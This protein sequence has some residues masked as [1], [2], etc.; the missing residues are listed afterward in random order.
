MPIRIKGVT[1]SRVG[2]I[3]STLGALVA[4]MRGTHVAP[5]NRSGR[6]VV[7]LGAVAASLRGQSSV[8]ANRNGRIATNLGTL[9]A[10]F[11]GTAT[12]PGTRNG[13]IIS[14]LGGLTSSL[15]GTSA[16]PA[17]PQTGLDFPGNLAAVN[18]SASIRFRWTGSAL[19]PIF[20][21]GGAGVTYIWKYRPL[22]HTG[23]YSTFFWGNDDGAGA[24]STFLWQS[25]AANSYYG[26]HPYPQGGA[27]GTVHNWEVSVEQNDF[28]GALVTKGVWHSQATRVR[29]AVNA[30]KEH[31]FYWNLPNLDAANRVFRTSPT[32]W[33]NVNPP[34]P[35]LTWAD[36]PWQPS[37]ERGAGVHRGIQ[38]YNAYLTTSQIVQLAALESDAAVLSMA[39]SLGLSSA[40]WY[41][42]MNPTPSDISDKSGAGHTPLWVNANRPALYSTDQPPVW[43]GLPSTITFTQGVAATYDVSQHVTDPDTPAAN[44][45][46]TKNATAL[47]IGVTFDAPQKR[48]VYDPTTPGSIVAGTNGHI[49]TA[50]D[51]TGAAGVDVTMFTLTSNTTATLP[52][53]IG[54]AF[55]Q[56]DIPSGQFIVSD[57]STF[58]GSIRNRWPDGSVKYAVLSGRKLLTNGTPSTVIVRRQTADPGGVNI[59]EST[60]IGLNPTVSMTLSSF[61]TVTLSAL[62]GS[63]VRSFLGTQMSEFHYRSAVGS[64]AHLAVWFYVRVY[65]GNAIEIE[66]CVENGYMKVASP[67]NKAYTAT[68]T[69]NGTTRY[70][71]ALT[72]WPRTRWFTVNW[73]DGSSG[74]TDFARVIPAHNAS[75]LRSTKLV[76]NYATTAA[77]TTAYLNGLP[78]NITPLGNGSMPAG[79]LSAGGSAPH[80]GILPQWAAS[81]CVNGDARAYRGTL[82]N[83]YCSNSWPV[84]YRDE[85][86]QR[87]LALTTRPNLDAAGWGID[88]V[89]AGTGSNGNSFGSGTQAHMP[90]AGY[91]AYLLTGR[92]TYLETAAF[93]A[94]RSHMEN[95]PTSRGLT[96]G[97]G[98]SATIMTAEDRGKSWHL[99]T[100]MQVVSIYP[101]SGLPA[102]D[103]LVR[104]DWLAALG[105]TWTWY[106]TNALACPLGYMSQHFNPGSYHPDQVTLPNLGVPSFMGYFHAQCVGYTWDLDVLSGTAKTSHTTCR[107]HFYKFP[108]GMC[109]DSSGWCFRAAAQFV[110]AIGTYNGSTITWDAT[111]AAAYARSDTSGPADI[112]P[113]ASKPCTAGG[114]IATGHWPDSTS[115]G[116]NLHPAIAYAV[117]HGATGAAAAYAR[118]QAAS[119][120]AAFVADQV[121][122]TQ[123]AIVPRT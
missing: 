55:K 100:S 63:P 123:W 71:A 34:A 61:G 8:P 32:T 49:L 50:D 60:L 76:P 28:I 22:Q 9:A 48:Y 84:C 72:H 119:N 38:I 108:V 1:D 26:M 95:N 43:T 115:Y 13:R 89:V 44:I 67:V 74:L 73:Y 113:D 7:G 86:T 46:I 114:S 94:A 36:A 109:G 62:F 87:P 101:D 122:A 66:T 16:A 70:T 33:G 14:S 96:S 103:A 85:S 105:A 39:S 88:P 106:T 79:S 24:L 104:S 20:G 52:F 30:V 82:V 45:G 18:Q 58:Q 19:V 51:Q 90:E 10:S 53:T 78:Q 37:H 57:L 118:L 59:A 112:I 83:A 40:L 121:N 3:Q 107:D 11:R 69:I 21:T 120:Y 99:R 92:W 4:S 31:E 35:A 97:N 116:G 65:Q 77:S 75:Y 23:Y 54:H 81:Y 111:W 12:P 56:G 27:S 5:P 41:L 93:W 6:I 80:I 117:E 47:P 102:A 17:V 42:N 110:I 68:L 2:R 98:G 25:G 15:R 29:G 64:D 91:T